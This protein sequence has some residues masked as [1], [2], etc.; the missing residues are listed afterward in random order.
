M[1][2]LHVF[3]MDGT[4]LHGSAC[5]EISRAIGVLEEN[6]AIEEAW[7]RGDFTD[8]VYWER[9]LPLWRDLNEAHIAA[10]FANA[11]WMARVRDVF[12]DI[13]ARG[14]HSAVITQSPR[15]FAE[16]LAE[17]GV[18]FAFGATIAPN[19]PASER[20]LVSSDEKLVITQ[21]LLEELGLSADACVAYGDSASDLALFR[22]LHN[23][24]GVNAKPAIRELA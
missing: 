2:C 6:V 23:T 15:F 18:S 3:D 24:V 21:Q 5:F 20:L 9:C 4:L 7:L 10:A 14:E 13:R 16:R 12:E 22:T 11:P 1:T 19:L 17:W 8:E